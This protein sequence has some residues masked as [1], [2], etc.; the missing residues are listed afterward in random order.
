MEYT[1]EQRTKALLLLVE[2]HGDVDKVADTLIDD[3]FQVPAD[4]LRYWMLDEH[5]E[6]YRRLEA[7]RGRRLEGEAISLMQETIRRVAELEQELVEAV[8]ETRDPRYLSNALR[9]VADTKTRS[10]NALL[11]LTGRPVSG[12]Q[13]GST[14]AML[15]LAQSL[16]EQG[17]LKPA[18]GVTLEAGPPVIDADAVEA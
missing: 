3:E 11:Q 15:K 9:A 13:A 10:T 16:V 6:Q 17:L 14:E 1:S 7:D 8:G 12:A 4:T 18:E 5:K 2:N